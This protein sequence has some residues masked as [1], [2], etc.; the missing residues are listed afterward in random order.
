MA[1]KRSGVRIPV[2]PPRSERDKFE[3]LSPEFTGLVQQQ[4]TAT[5]QDD[6]P[7]RQPGSGSST[8]RGCWH[9]LLKRHAKANSERLTRKDV[10]FCTHL[11]LALAPACGAFR[12]VTPAACATRQASHARPGRC[13][14]SSHDCRRTAPWPSMMRRLAP[15]AASSVSRRGCGAPRRNLAHPEARHR[16]ARRVTAH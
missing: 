16:A 8:W 2:A 3:I 4:N 6:V 14:V 11:P 9:G 12:P 10:P 15:G 1:C 7:V 13:S 5:Q